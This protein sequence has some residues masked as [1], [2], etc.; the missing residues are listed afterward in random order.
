MGLLIDS[1]VLIEHE[2]GRLDLARLLEG[3]AE[4]EAFLSAITASELLHGVQRA[5]TPAER[6][7]RLASVEVLLSAFPVLPVDL[8][9]AR[10]HAQVWAELRAAGTPIGPHDL[11]I[12]ATCLAHGHAVATANVREFARVPGLVVHSP[13]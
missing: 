3:T 13:A 12:A 5:R 6:A 7:R 4:G 11:W 1:S 8:T 10:V 9:V 2:R